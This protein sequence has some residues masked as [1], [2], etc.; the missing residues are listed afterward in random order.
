MNIDRE[1]AEKVMKLNPAEPT[2]DS[3]KWGNNEYWYDQKNN[4]LTVWQ[5]GGRIWSPSTN[6]KHAMEVEA[7]MFRRGYETSIH[8]DEL[9][10][11]EAQFIFSGREISHVNEIDTLPEAICLAAL[12]ALK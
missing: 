4:I 5:N 2:I 1:I 8:H 10:G 6:I 3:E 11:W 9:F 7:E 12:E